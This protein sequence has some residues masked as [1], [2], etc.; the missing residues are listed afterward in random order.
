MG[1]DNVNYTDLGKTEFADLSNESKEFVY[2]VEDYMGVPVE[3]IG[4]GPHTLD[5]ISVG[6]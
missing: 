4:T 1:I 3:Y 2:S 5:I 6:A